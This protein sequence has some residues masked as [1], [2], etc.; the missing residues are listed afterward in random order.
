[1]YERSHDMINSRNQQYAQLR[2]KMA[3]M[4]LS[5]AARADIPLSDMPMRDMNTKPKKPC[6]PEGADKC[7]NG[8]GLYE[9][10]LAMAYAPYQVWR[11][12]YCEDNALEKGTLFSELDLPFEG[13]DK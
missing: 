8:W 9:Y 3:E 2:K 7:H 10:P 4:G 5:N 6:N 12:T 13:C 11:S 1:M